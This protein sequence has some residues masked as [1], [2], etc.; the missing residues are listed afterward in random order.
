MISPDLISP[1]G[2]TMRRIDCAVTL[3]PQPLSPM[4]PRV[5]FGATEKLTPSTAFSVPSSSLK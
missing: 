1:G 2:G 5:F 4:M 3:L